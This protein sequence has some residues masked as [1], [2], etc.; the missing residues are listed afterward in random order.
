M[1]TRRV[2]A[3]ESASLRIRSSR[4]KEV[5]GIARKTRE[6]SGML[7]ETESAHVP[8]IRVE[9]GAEINKQSI[10]SHPAVAIARNTDRITF[11]R[12]YTLCALRACLKQLRDSSTISLTYQA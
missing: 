12:H 3:C 9:R 6:R 1:L 4:L 2:H 11:G 5:L 7:S 10:D 8:P